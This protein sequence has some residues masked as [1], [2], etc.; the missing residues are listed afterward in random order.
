MK[1]WQEGLKEQWSSKLFQKDEGA[2]ATAEANAAALAQ[3]ALLKQL[4]ELDESTIKEAFRE[5][6][7]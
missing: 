6:D 4:I 1:L 2:Q 7:G 5:N 3:F